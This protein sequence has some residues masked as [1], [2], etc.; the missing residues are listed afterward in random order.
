MDPSKTALDRTDRLILRE[1][2]HNA[3]LTNK[4]LAARVHL[5][6]SSCHARVARLTDRGVL[7]GSH[8]DI[9]P[10]ALGVGLRTLVAVRLADHGEKRSRKVIDQVR[11]LPEVVD[12]FLTAGHD[13]LF[14]HVAVRDTDHLR[15]IVLDTIGSLP[16]VAD[17][18]SSLIYEHHRRAAFP[19]LLGD[20]DE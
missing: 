6:P 1:L 10:K 11:E 5:A 20:D 2:T 19:D 15:E 13:D 12:V 16:E 17:I 8:A 9:D 3:R 14:L 4:E 7:R 18:R